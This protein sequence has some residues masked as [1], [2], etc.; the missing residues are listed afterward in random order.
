[1]KKVFARSF[2]CQMNVYDSSRMVDLLK[3]INYE[4]TDKI[5]DADLII[6]NTC[7]IRENAH[8]K[9]FGLLGKA[10]HIKESKSLLRW[11]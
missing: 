8:N 1:M 4:E 2:G 10:K 11:R 7:S 6:V 3:D 5:E 9:A